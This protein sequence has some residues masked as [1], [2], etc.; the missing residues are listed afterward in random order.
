VGG[1]DT[2]R[3]AGYLRRAAELIHADSDRLARI[4]SLE[5]GKPLRESRFEV[6]GWTAGFF[7]Y[8]SGFARAAHGEILPSDHRGEEIEI[9]RVPYGVC[10]AITP[11]NF[12]SAMVARTV[13]PALMAGNAM[14]VKP[15]S[16]TPL[17][18]LAR[19]D[20]RTRPGSQPGS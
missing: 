10:V 8:F 17:S 2:G 16:T 7:E 14:M 9:R 11:W 20:L 18:A 6:E 19:C 5:E 1:A 4:S 13:A 15:S 12:P 3:R